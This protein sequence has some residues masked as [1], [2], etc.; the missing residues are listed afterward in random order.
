[1]TR[2]GNTFRTVR[3]GSNHFVP[4]EIEVQSTPGIAT[5]SIS[6]YARLNRNSPL[7]NTVNPEYSATPLAA[8]RQ[9]SVI[10]MCL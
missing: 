7:C 2:R 6:A 4:L 3:T 1:M 9:T 10:Q 5:P 8:I